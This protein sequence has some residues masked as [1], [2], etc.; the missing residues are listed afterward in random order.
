MGAPSNELRA[1]SAPSVLDRPVPRVRRSR[2]RDDTPHG[3]LR[4][5]PWHEL[6]LLYCQL[7][8]RCEPTGLVVLLA[9]PPHGGLFCP[10]ALPPGASSPVA[11]GCL[12]ASRVTVVA[13]LGQGGLGRGRSSPPRARVRTMRAIMT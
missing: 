7:H 12:P 10:G 6:N 3:G 4:H 9:S 1:L 5:S 11:Q 8:S 2:A 13:S